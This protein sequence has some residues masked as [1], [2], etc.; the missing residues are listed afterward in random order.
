MEHR[1]VRS[2]ASAKM[3]PLVKPCETPALGSPDNIY[4]L[5]HSKDVRKDFIANFHVAGFRI[6]ADFPQKPRRI[7]PSPFEVP[8]ERFG[9]AFRRWNLHQTDLGRVISVFG[10]GFALNHNARASL[11]DRHGNNVAVFRE[12]LRHAQLFTQNRLQHNNSAARVAVRRQLLC[13]LLPECFDLDVNPGGKIE[14]GQSVDRLRRRL[15]DIYQPFVRPDFKLF[16]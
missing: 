5:V 16:A 13:V 1:S 9:N 14:F 12:D 8:F 2:P 6:Q 4:F 7:R 10:G 3:V 15:E 11:Q